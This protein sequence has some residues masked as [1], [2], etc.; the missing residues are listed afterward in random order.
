MD[1]RRWTR[2]KELFGEALELPREARR[3]MV[4]GSGEDAEVIGEVLSLLSAH[5][6]PD[7]GATVALADVEGFFSAARE[8][9][10]QP[11]ERSIDAYRLIRPLG[12]GGMGE[13]WLAEQ[14]EPVRRAVALKVIKLGMDTK[15]V[16]ARFDAERQALAVMDHPNI[17]KVYDGGATPEGRPYFVMELVDGEPLTEYA[18]RVRASVRERIAT[19]LDV[20][21][22]VQH[23]HLKGVVHRDLKPTNLLVVTHDDRPVVKV[24]DFGVAKALERDLTDQTLQTRVDQA[25]G[26]PLYMS[27]EQA[28]ADLDVDSRSDVYSLGVVLHELL[29]GRRPEVSSDPSASPHDVGPP[30]GRPS[31]LL[32]RSDTQGAA[33]DLRSMTV[34]SLRSELRGDLDWIVLRA[35]EHERERRYQTAGDL[36]QDLQRFLSNEPVEARPPSTSY[37]VQRFVRRHRVGVAAGAVAITAILAGAVTATVGM[38]RAQRAE[39]LAEEEAA[40]TR[41]VSNFMVG[42]F[43][44]GD[45]GLGGAADLTA[46]DILDRGAA[47]VEEGLS[48]QPLVQARLLSALGDAYAGLNYWTVETELKERAAALR[49][50]ALGPTHPLVA[51][52][53]VDVT[54]S[55]ERTRPGDPEGAALMERIRDIRALRRDDDPQAWLDATTATEWWRQS[56]GDGETALARLEALDDSL[57]RELGEAHPFVRQV[58]DERARVYANEGRFAEATPLWE[59]LWATRSADEGVTDQSIGLMNNLA[60]GLSETGR[61]EESVDWLRRVLAAQEERLGSTTDPRLQP[62]I[63]NLAIVSQQIGEH[64][65][66][67]ALWDRLLDLYG[68]LYGPDYL[69]LSTYFTYR[70]DTEWRQGRID[71]AEASLGEARRIADYWMPNDS[72]GDQRYWGSADLARIHASVSMAAGRDDEVFDAANRVR[73]LP[74]WAFHADVAVAAAAEDVERMDVAALARRRAFRS[75][76]AAEREVPGQLRDEIRDAGHAAVRTYLIEGDAQGL[77]DLGRRWVA[78]MEAQPDDAAELALEARRDLAGLLFLGHPEF[79]AP[80]LPAARP[81]AVTYLR[82]ALEQRE[83]ELGEEHPGLLTHLAPLEIALRATGDDAGAGVVRRRAMELVS[84]E[85]ERLTREADQG[86]EEGA[87]PANDPGR[88]RSGAWNHLCWWGSLTGIGAEVLDACDRAVAGSSGDRRHE[89]HDSRGL[90]RALTGDIDGAIADFQ[91][92]VDALPTDHEGAQRRRAWIAALQADRNPF[93]TDVLARLAF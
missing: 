37:R 64:A 67:E 42:L 14:S 59:S 20:C 12:S 83:R 43:R 22:A 31:D 34:S 92:Y 8:A 79:G 10:W 51:D 57:T 6:A 1:A 60:F 88:D 85:H 5:E 35:M 91:V 44:A 2:V 69:N 75:L 9:D 11:R 25:V 63:W 24:I 30:L 13:V 29:T 27:P 81:E 26:T 17:A 16:V 40:V 7:D 72:L 48:G 84:A 28:R 41:E 78:L 62:S 54:R 55:W 50:A 56:A 39:A 33:A 89:R 32:A 36:A 45:P 15:E 18:D 52:A 87:D 58:R 74:L 86:G 70:A 21:A 3:G 47:Q 77:R 73:D 19:F 68:D 23:A 38:V 93:T 82:L 80:M 61:M 4:V 71:E 66:A 65:D 90:A 49:E 46:R 53:L 76:E